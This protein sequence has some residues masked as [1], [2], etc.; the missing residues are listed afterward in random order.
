MKKI[1][2]ELLFLLEKLSGDNLC[3]YIIRLF[4]LA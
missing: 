4:P 1:P 3:G 2:R